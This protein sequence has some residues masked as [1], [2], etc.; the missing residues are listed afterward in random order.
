MD[1]P[2]YTLSR[3]VYRLTQR[4]VQEATLAV[5]T[6]P[7]S[8]LTEMQSVALRVGLGALIRE[9]IATGRWYERQQQHVQQW[10]SADPAWTEEPPTEP[11]RPRG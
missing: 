1:E 10:Q 8:P 3:A 6:G 9:A 5:S 4:A 11:A 2:A 7:L